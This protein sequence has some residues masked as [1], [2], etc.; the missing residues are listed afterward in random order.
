[1]VSN[2]HNKR[3]LPP[4]SALPAFEAAARHQSFSRAAEEL[5]LTHGA[6][7]RAVAQ[8]E[9]RLGVSLFQRRSRRVWLTPAGERLLRATSAALDQLGEAVEGLQLHDS[10]SPLLTISCEPSLAMRWLM[11]RLGRFREAHPELNIDLR[12]AGGPID[13]LAE[14]C[15]LAIRRTD[16][17]LPSDAELTPL[18]SEVAGPVC[19]PNCWEN[20]LERDL[21]KARLLHSRTRP[22]AWDSW[23]RASGHVFTAASEQY[24]DHFFFALQA[25]ANR[26]GTA[27]GPLPLVYD[28]LMAGRLIAPFGMAST[29]YDYVLISLERPEQD[30][31]IEAFHHWLMAE[32]H[33]MESAGLN[34]GGQQL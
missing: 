10:A 31:R 25:A 19:D 34:Q 8:I 20:L 24:Y 14:G 29:G 13:L 2:T 15:D 32:I 16:F 3:R 22:D 17:G 26:L 9:D 28:D 23:Q 7:S 5:H 12:M 21:S 30:S 1:M 33:A 27:I 4:L 11:P 18:W 6:I